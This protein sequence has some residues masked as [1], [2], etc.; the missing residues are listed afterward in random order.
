[1]IKARDRVYAEAK[2]VIRLCGIFAIYDV[3]QREGGDVLSPG[4][5]GTGFAYQSSGND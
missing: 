1:M 2:R 4:S 3:L 5:L